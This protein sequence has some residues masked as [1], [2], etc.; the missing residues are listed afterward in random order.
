MKPD[1]I[2]R[3]SHAVIKAAVRVREGHS[4]VNGIEFFIEGPH[5][6]ESALQ[7]KRFSLLRVFFTEEFAGRSDGWALL[8]RTEALLP[9]GSA[10]GVSDAVMAKLSDTKTPQGIAAIVS[11]PQPGLA[12]LSLSPLPLLVA[13][14]RVQDPGNM[15]TIIR[16]A[17]A[18]GADGVIVLPGSCNPFMPK[19]VRSSA[20]SIIHLPVV[21]SAPEDLA[22]YAK[23]RAV[24]LIGADAW[25]EKDCFS[26][27]LRRPL[28][29]VL[30]NEAHG[31]SRELGAHITESVRVPIVGQAESL[32]VAAS[33][34]VLLYET[35]RQRG[36]KKLAQ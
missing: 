2:T 23:Q 13:C 19:A 8:R 5:L 7:A 21:F 17:D 10:I 35:M 36:E 15:G 30:G 1:R 20:G 25:A 24:A 27:D 32:N 4:K 26:A 34:A 16:L 33:A 6:L 12:D 18:F 29:L 31:I 22:A 3:S 9:K 14:D 28:I 11:C